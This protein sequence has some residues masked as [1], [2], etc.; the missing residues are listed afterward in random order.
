M[1]HLKKE[2]ESQKL[3]ELKRFLSSADT[4]EFDNSQTPIVSII[5][6]LYNR[7]ELTFA[8]LKSIKQNCQLPV[9]IVCIDNNST[10]LTK[11]L[12][13]KVS[14]VKYIGNTDNKG[15]LLACNQANSYASGKYLLFLNNDAAIRKSAIE[16]ALGVFQ[17]EKNVGAVGAKILLLDGNLQEAG[18]ITW[19][20][21]SCLGYGRGQSPEK[22]KFMFRRKVN[23][24]SGAFLL[25]PKKLFEKLGGFD[26]Q[27][28]PAYYEETD[29][30][31]SLQEAGYDVYY[32]PSSVID[33]F[34]FASSASNEDAIELQKTNKSKFFEKHKEYLSHMPAPDLANVLAGRQL[35]DKKKFLFIDD[36]IPH[37]DLGAGFPRSNLI[38]SMLVEL[39]Y[40]V[41]VYSLNFPKEDTWE[42]IYRDLDPKVEVIVDYRRERISKFIEERKDYYD[43]IWVSRPHNFEFLID[44]IGDFNNC[45]VIYDAEAVFSERQIEKAKLSGEEIDEEEILNEE[46]AL[47]EYADAVVTVKES[48][49]ELF[50]K[51]GNDYTH[52]LNVAFKIPEYLAPFESR[53]DLL[54]VGNLDFDDSPN[55]DSIMWFVQNV[56][57]TFK[58][59]VP[60]A[61]LHLVGSNKSK[62]IRKL[63]KQRKDV[64]VHGRLDDLTNI[65][66]KCKIFLAPTRYAAGSPAK[67]FLAAAYGVP[68]IAT[69]LII[70][71]LQW[72]KES[73]IEGCD[74]KNPELFTERLI[75]LYTD[76]N[77]WETVQSNALNVIKHNHSYKVYKDTLEHIV[78]STLKEATERKI[79]KRE[80]VDI[81]NIPLQ[82]IKEKIDRLNQEKLE[83]QDQV[84]EGEK[85][86]LRLLDEISNKNVE[87]QKRGQII[88]ELEKSIFHKMLR[89]LSLP[90]IYIKRK[91]NT[92][93]FYLAYAFKFA[94]AFIRNPLSSLK[95]LSFDNIKRF[96][97]A[98]KEEPISVVLSNIKNKLS[99]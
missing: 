48:D 34:E 61:K 25:T 9:E 14:G 63:D 74:H 46:L 65:F 52:V 28:C 47:S 18:S 72:I 5:L 27:F 70:R 66:N 58:K 36:R 92:L 78:S 30:C 82:K 7:A 12:F 91:F 2:F 93:G 60:D 50:Y 83:L 29:Y 11:E 54:F 57:D 73:Q 62:V 22:A 6:I 3:E 69:D 85:Y 16:N 67:A 8:C 55:V 24:C 96:F 97:K 56:F 98:I 10:D 15:F 64:M 19:N 40:E 41:S 53:Q 21:G 88:A 32:E 49:K 79:K 89:N 81:T 26:E 35:N 13:K 95:Q 43:L 94:I 71:Q 31:I 80:E 68:I 75:H 23:F 20:D 33:H 84:I 39:G 86:V 45:K 1:D 51:Y 59:Q 44:K 38:I 76:K 4:L 99:E 37:E 17:S 77:H 90:F 87:I 42:D